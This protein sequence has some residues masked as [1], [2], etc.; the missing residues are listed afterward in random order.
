[1]RLTCCITPAYIH[2]LALDHDLGPGHTAL[3]LAHSAMTLGP[4]T[5]TAAFTFSVWVLQQRFSRSPGLAALLS[6]LALFCLGVRTGLLT[7]EDLRL[8]LDWVEYWEGHRAKREDLN[9]PWLVRLSDFQPS[10]AC[11][12]HRVDTLADGGGG[13]ISEPVQFQVSRLRTRLQ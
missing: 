13:E 7:A 1:M 8:L 10:E 2:A 11:L 5:S 3:I 6:A 9:G 4:E 12:R